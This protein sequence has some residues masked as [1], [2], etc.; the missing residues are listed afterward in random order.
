MTLRNFRLSGQP[1]RCLA[2]VKKAFAMRVVEAHSRPPVV[3]GTSSTSITEPPT[4]PGELAHAVA[5][6]LDPPRPPSV[7]RMVRDL[8]TTC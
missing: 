1:L 7:S 5:G 4:A 8:P 2:L 3:P 6:P